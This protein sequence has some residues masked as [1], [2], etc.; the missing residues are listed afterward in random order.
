MVPKTSISPE[1][2]VGRLL[3]DYPGLEE[4][5]LAVVLDKKYHW[6]YFEKNW[7]LWRCQ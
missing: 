6:E 5:P 1:T 7:L 3:E 2:K 4:V